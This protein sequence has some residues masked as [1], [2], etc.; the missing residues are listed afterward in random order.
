MGVG[1]CGTIAAGFGSA[2]PEIGE[3]IE[4][5]NFSSVF[6]G[7][8]VVLVPGVVLVVPWARAAFATVV[9]AL[10]EIAAA[11]DASCATFV[12][13]GML[14]PVFWFGFASA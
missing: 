10:A 2:A 3:L 1:S 14:V 12:W 5:S 6:A 8:R 13:A 4:S 7:R 9:F 11:N